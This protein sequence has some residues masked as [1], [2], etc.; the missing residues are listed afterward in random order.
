MK[1]PK[2]KGIISLEIVAYWFCIIGHSRGSGREQVTG[3]VR[4]EQTSGFL[5]PTMSVCTCITVMTA[6]VQYC[7][8]RDGLWTYRYYTYIHTVHRV[9]NHNPY[10]CTC[11]SYGTRYPGTGSASATVAL[12]L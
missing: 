10:H 3:K 11:N 6:I 8:F 1:G 12:I 4:G 9:R 7:T 2:Q 5:I